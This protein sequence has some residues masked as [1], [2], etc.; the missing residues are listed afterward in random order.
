M[1]RYVYYNSVKYII[2]K[3]KLK[4]RILFLVLFAV[5]NISFTFASSNK[6]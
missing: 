5:S 6:K 4:E 2:Y 1:Q 3:I